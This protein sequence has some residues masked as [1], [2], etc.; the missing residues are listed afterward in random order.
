VAKRKSAGKEPI[1]EVEEPK[2]LRAFIAEAEL[3]SLMTRTPGWEVLERDVSE[4]IKKLGE[5]IPYLN[6]KSDECLSARL[7]Y[8]ASDK[9]LK[10]V[11]DYANNRAEALAFLD[12]LD[13][14]KEN[15][16]L[17]VDNQN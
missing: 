7:L 10:I 3:V 9:L 17:D 6:P 11:T 4:Y 8:I 15:I 12:K 16:V 14:T 5:R 1:L 13:N 2:D